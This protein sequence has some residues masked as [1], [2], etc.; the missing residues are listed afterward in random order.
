MTRQTRSDLIT[1][2]ARRVQNDSTTMKA[3]IR[4]AL[5]DAYREALDRHR[6]TDLIRWVDALV[7]ITAGTAHFY[8]PKDVDFLIAPQET[9]TV[10]NVGLTQIESILRNSMGYAALTGLSYQA[11]YEGASG[12]NASISNEALEVVSDAADAREGWI[13]G[14][15]NGIRKQTNFTLNGTTPVA[16]G[17][18][19][20]VVG[21][22]LE[23]QGTQSV[24]IRK[25][26]GSTVIGTVGPQETRAEYKK[27]RLFEVPGQN[28]TLNVA[29]Y[30][31]PAPIYDDGQQYE[32][33]IE[34]YL[35]ESGLAAAY[36]YK[37]NIK[38]ATYHDNKAERA[39][40]AVMLK[41]ARQGLQQATPRN[42]RLS[43]ATH[44]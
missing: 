20:T 27:Y 44:W 29:Y 42:R 11:A 36:L 26:T 7:S 14:Y 18:W 33:P 15:L 25:V 21:F 43:R 5:D 6:W 3:V 24:D 2:I 8:L 16:V 23:T 34:Q 4:D 31:I 22:S 17:S 32:L 41:Q 10:M 1:S 35:H 19:D 28:S 38:Q 40:Q 37:R 12:I 30:R 39:L 13:V 9:T